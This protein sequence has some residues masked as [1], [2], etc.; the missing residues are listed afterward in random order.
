MA[1]NSQTE[2]Y[3]TLERLRRGLAAE[4]PE[5]MLARVQ[6]QGF[7]EGADLT[8]AGLRELLEWPLSTPQIVGL[9]A[10]KAGRKIDTQRT[11][12]ALVQRGL[13]GDDGS[14]TPWGMRVLYEVDRG[15]G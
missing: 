14:V 15:R 3:R 10:A 7:A 1:V 2:K 6:R 13:L 11:A 9:R 8:A 4:V 12:D 5:A